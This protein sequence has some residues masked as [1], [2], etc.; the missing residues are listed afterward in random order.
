M[1]YSTGCEY[2]IRALIRLA[3]Q[4]PTGGLCRLQDL[5]DND[6]LPEQFVGKLLQVLVRADLLV[7]SRGRGGGFALRTLPRE[8]VLRQIVEAIDGKDRT[9]RCILGLS[10]CDEN[11]AC[12]QHDCWVGIRRQIDEVLD[13]TTLADLVEAMSRKQSR[14]SRRR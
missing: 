11:Q 4:A 2:A 10:A 1:I 14:L 7:S 8:I 5:V 9:R 13:K 3:Q 12:P 6:N